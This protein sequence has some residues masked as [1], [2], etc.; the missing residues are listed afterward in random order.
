[1]TSGRN[2]V[3][4]SARPFNCISNGYTNNFGSCVSKEVRDSL[5]GKA[6]TI[7]A[8][9][10][11]TVSVGFIVFN[12]YGSW[13]GIAKFDN[14]NIGS[15]HVRK[16]LTI[17]NFKEPK[18][19]ALILYLQSEKNDASDSTGIVT[20]TNVKLELGDTATIWT[21]APEDITSI[22]DRLTALETKVNQT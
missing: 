10:V 18:D 5:I 3:I 13:Q 19:N 22:Y 21:P 7:S 14:T 20:L 4:N 17:N 8:D 16:T 11:N 1:M 2:Y 12:V 9:Y 15:G 6:V